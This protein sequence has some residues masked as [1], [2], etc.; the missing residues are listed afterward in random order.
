MSIYIYIYI[1]PITPFLSQ[2]KVSLCIPPAP[3]VLQQELM[4]DE[5]IGMDMEKARNESYG[6]GFGFRI[7]ELGFRI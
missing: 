3:A 4:L 2:L 5:L 6:L 1:T 7:W